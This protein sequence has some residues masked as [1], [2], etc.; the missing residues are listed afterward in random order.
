MKTFNEFI[1]ESNQF[2]RS[3]GKNDA[4]IDDKTF[5]ELDVRDLFFKCNYYPN[6]ENKFDGKFHVYRFGDFRNNCITYI[7]VDNEIC[8]YT[9]NMFTQKDMNSDIFIA[10]VSDNTHYALFSNLNAAKPYIESIC[11]ATIFTEEEREMLA[12]YN[13][14]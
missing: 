7:S 14:I 9:R 12:P 6:R 1:N 13:I 8:K 11:P 3:I 2:L 5:G 4:V 10:K